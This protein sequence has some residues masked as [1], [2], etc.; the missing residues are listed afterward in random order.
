MPMRANSLLIRCFAFRD[1]GVWV[2]CS[3]ELGLAAQ[4]ESLEGAKKKLDAQINSYMHD[5][6]YGEDRAHADELLRRKAP[7]SAYAKYYVIKAKIAAHLVK[8][9]MAQIFA[10]PAVPMP[11]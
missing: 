9:N 5:A 10:V 6:L 3:L 7:A 11:A 4:A 8:R 1:E 2:A